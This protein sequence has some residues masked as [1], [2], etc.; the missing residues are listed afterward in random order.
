MF[1]VS[2]IREGLKKFRGWLNDLMETSWKACQYTDVLIESPSAM[3]GIHIA[4]KLEIPYFRAFPFPWTRTRAFP[5]PFAVPERNLGRGYNYMT[6]TTIEQVFWKGISGQINKWRQQSLGLPPTTSDRMEAHRVPTLYSWSPS[7]VPAPMDWHSWVHVT[8]YW[9]LDNPDHSWTPPDGL[10]EFLEADPDNKPVYIGFG[11]MVVS[12]PEEMTRTII[13]AVLKSGVRAVISKGWSDKSG[14]KVETKT[15]NYPDSIFM[16]DSVPHDWL[17]HRL[18]GVVHHGGAGTTAAGLRAGVPTVIKPYFGD[19]YFWA[20]RVEDDGVGVWCH[21]LTVKKLSTALSTITTDEKLIKKAQLMGERIRAEDGVGTAIQYFYHDLALAKE[22][23]ED[24]QKQK[25]K[26]SKFTGAKQDRGVAGTT[27]EDQVSEKKSGPSVTTTMKHYATF[28]AT[29]DNTSTDAA[30]SPRSDHLQPSAT[31]PSPDHFE[32]RANE[33]NENQSPVELAADLEAMQ[34]PRLHQSTQLAH[35]G[36]SSSRRGQGDDNDDDNE[37]YRD[38]SEDNY[39]DMR[40][41]RKKQSKIRKA[42]K[43][44]K[45]KAKHVR[46]RLEPSSLESSTLEQRKISAEEQ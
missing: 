13:E 16:L 6:Y 22:R 44:L 4:E 34:P 32:D 24:Q 8:G 31:E 46:D 1:T 10:E 26:M 21:D 40:G 14:S 11:S 37:C 41:T 15:P 30:I 17:F 43:S 35:V 38:I 9:F 42:M 29:N 36:Y 28:G 7:V 3:T 25:E 33:R 2:F 23:L 27:N 5:H 20:Q 39:E 19:Q 18:A 45:V 12:D